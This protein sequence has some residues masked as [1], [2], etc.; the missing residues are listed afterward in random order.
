M[1][2]VAAVL[3][4]LLAVAGLG[5]GTPAGTADTVAT[6]VADV[7]EA[8]LPPPAVVGGGHPATERSVSIVGDSILLGAVDQVRSTLTASGWDPTIATFP[9]LPLAVGA[10]VL[11]EEKAAGQLGQIVV[12]HLGNNL[13]TNVDGFVHDLDATMAILQDV[14]FVVWMTIQTFH[15]SLIQVDDAL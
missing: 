5:I 13:P 14:P 3:A 7:A 4:W 1:G 11:A 12:I 10:Q 8:A 9:G 15:P 6:A 2:P